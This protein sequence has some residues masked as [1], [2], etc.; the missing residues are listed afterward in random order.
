MILETGRLCI[1][2]YGRDAGSKAV[3][4][5]VLDNGFVNVLTTKRSRKE[6]P[7]NPNHLEFLPEKIDT[8]DK[9]AVLKALGVK[10]TRQFT[11]KASQKAQ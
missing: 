3:I 6:R 11:T 2:K 1:K 10:E 8:N 4:T 9:A 7:C 5:K